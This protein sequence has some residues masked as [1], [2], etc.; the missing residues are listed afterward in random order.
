MCD[1]N[2]DIIMEVANGGVRFKGDGKL[3]FPQNETSFEILDGPT[4]GYIEGSE[5]CYVHPRED[6]HFE[7]QRVV[8][9]RNGQLYTRSGKQ[10]NLDSLSAD[11]HLR[12]LQANELVE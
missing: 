10:L 9:Y 3:I 7:Y 12:L 1:S 8:V 5:F 2:T 11:F 6:E 4:L